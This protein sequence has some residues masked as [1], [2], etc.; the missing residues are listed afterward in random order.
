LQADVRQNPK[1]EV[2]I[3]H[4][5]EKERHDVGKDRTLGLQLK[6]NSVFTMLAT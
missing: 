4:N 1:S 5:I 6:Q 2:R 3:L